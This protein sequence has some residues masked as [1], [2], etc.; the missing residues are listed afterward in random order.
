MARIIYALSGQGRG[1]TSRVIAISDELR[2]AG[3]ELLF[4]GGGTAREILGS[5]G[6]RMLSVPPLR[7]VIEGN[8]LRFFSTIACNWESIVG[9][10]GIIT[11]LADEFA[12][13]KPHLLI[14][15]F[16]AFSPRAAQRIG[17][18][19][20][21]FNHQQVV[22]ETRYELPPRF[23]MNAILTGA[24][25]RL[26]APRNPAHV[27]ITSFF[28]SPLKRPERTTL[29]PPIIRPVI[30]SISPVRGSHVLVY[31]NHPKGAEYVLDVL[32]QV[33]APFV[34]YNFDKPERPED[35]PNVVFK[36]PSLNG[37][38]EDLASCRAVISTAGFTLTSEALFLGKPLLVAPNDGIFEQTINAIFLE[39]EGLGRTV[40]GR[41]IT[42]RDVTAFLDQHT[43]Y[44][45][46]LQNR[47]NSGNEHAVACIEK[48]LSRCMP[49]V[50][51]RPVFPA[52]KEERL[53]EACSAKPE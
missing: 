27:L 31:F 21:S 32:R 7:Q 10:T 47:N 37:F 41:P 26:I 3:H 2:R 18:P 1:H 36:Q 29:V 24:A 43:I 38:L 51:S 53:P 20:L 4:C 48:V 40:I 33:D 39:R 23:R 46:R 12:S 9:M 11:Q 49:S 25:I 16:E 5:E 13:F 44:E 35:Y 22:T 30:Q 42:V 15:D 14:T 8:Q 6:E 17:L 52:E 45:G 19:V 50:H 34:V 28:Y